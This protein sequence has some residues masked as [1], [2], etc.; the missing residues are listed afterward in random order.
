MYEIGI[1]PIPLAHLIYK[2]FFTKLLKKLLIEPTVSFSP[3][4]CALDQYCST[5]GFQRPD[6][7]F[8]AFCLRR[9]P[10]DLF[11]DVIIDA[12]TMDVPQLRQAL[13]VEEQP[14]PP[15]PLRVRQGTTLQVPPLRIPH[16]A[17]I[18]LQAALC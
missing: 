15:P 3:Y 18:Q 2:R 12:A 6:F 1:I 9:L 7:S 4:W 16:Q 10:L 14:D 13:S 5:H 11:L 17:K 8:Y